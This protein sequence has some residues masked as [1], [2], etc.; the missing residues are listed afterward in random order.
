ME[1]PNGMVRIGTRRERDGERVAGS[2]GLGSWE[3]AIIWL[4]EAQA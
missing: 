3:G 1:L 4:D 2:L